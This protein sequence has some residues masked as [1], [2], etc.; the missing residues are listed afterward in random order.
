[1]GSL[2]SHNPNGLHGLLRG[3]LY[4]YIYILAEDL[5]VIVK[6]KCGLEKL[7]ELGYDIGVSNLT[8]GC[9]TF[10]SK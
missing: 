6:R 1:V 10:L 5:G 4:F 9:T 3:E 7:P 8:F 2:T